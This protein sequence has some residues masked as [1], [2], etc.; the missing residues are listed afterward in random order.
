[1]IEARGAV[2]SIVHRDPFA[3]C[4]HPHA[5]VSRAGMWMVV[6]NRAPR[7]PFV[8]HPPEDPLFRN[9]IVRSRD[10]GAS[11]TAPEVV[12]GYDISGTECA[13]LTPLADG[14]VLM[15]QWQFDWYPLGLARRLP[16]Q[17]QLTYPDVFMRGWLASPEHETG[18]IAA[19]PA[20]LAP[21]VRG[22][23]RTFVHRSTDDGASWGKTARVD[24]APFSGGYAMRGGVEL[25]DGTILLLLSDVPNYRVVFAIRSGDGGRSWSAPAPVARGDGHDFEEPALARCPSGRLVAVLRDNA[26]R[27]LHQVTSGDSGRSWSAPSRL[28]VEGYPAHLLALA[29]GRLLMTYGWR[30]PDFGIRAVVSDDE[31]E[32]WDID[33]T[34]R[35]RGGLGNRNLGY[36]STIMADDGSLFTVYYAEDASRC[37]CIMATTWRLE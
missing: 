27:R 24:T 6:F 4:A 31:G 12:P 36:P 3:Y 11:W 9:V 16:D 13:G 21:W 8:L 29:D 14:S 25:P 7:R 10:R 22:G 2:H 26:S 37:T 34:I 18:G 33:A 30:Q 19:D 20:T 32:T 5:A 15:S 17:G 35:I 1:M 23:G 28:P